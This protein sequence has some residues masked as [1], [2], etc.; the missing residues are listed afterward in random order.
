M[1]PTARPRRPA[2]LDVLVLKTLAGGARH[3][4]AIARW[5]RETTDALLTAGT[6]SRLTRTKDNLHDLKGAGKD[7]ARVLDFFTFFEP[8]AR[9]IRSPTVGPKISAYA[10][11]PIVAMA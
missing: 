8:Y 4:Y 10:R 7:G 9:R 5:I 2:T 11:L 1:E 6:V 3:G